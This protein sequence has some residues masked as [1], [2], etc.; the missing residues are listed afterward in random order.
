MTN[1]KEISP[2]PDRLLWF[3]DYVCLF[4]LAGSEDVSPIGLTQNADGDWG[5]LEGG[6]WVS[7]T[8]PEGVASLSADH[9]LYSSAKKAAEGRELWQNDL[10][11][12]FEK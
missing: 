12:R 1:T 10:L 9:D 3:N 4:Y 8:I 7:V 11:S 6:D 5:Y 2:G